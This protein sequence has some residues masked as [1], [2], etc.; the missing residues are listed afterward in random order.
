MKALRRHLIV[1]CRSLCSE[2]LR[3]NTSSAAKYSFRVNSLLNFKEASI[4]RAPESFL[5]VVIQ[6]IVLIHVCRCTNHTVK[7]LR[8]RGNRGI[9]CSCYRTCCGVKHWEGEVARSASP[10]WVQGSLYSIVRSPVFAAVE[11]DKLTASVA[12]D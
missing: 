10:I 6:L 3:P 11:K 8:D 9:L 4:V 2:H 12:T 5:E 7:L 1:Q